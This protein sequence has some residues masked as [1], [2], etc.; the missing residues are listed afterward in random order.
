MANQRTA[1]KGKKTRIVR[2]RRKQRSVTVSAG[3][4][5]TASSHAHS[6]K[7]LAVVLVGPANHV[8]AFAK[9]RPHSLEFFTRSASEVEEL[10]ERLKN[11]RPRRPKPR[12]QD[13][14]EII[15]RVEPWAGS[16]QKA[17]RWFRSQ[18]I[19][20]LGDQTAEAL[21]RTGQA[22]LV[23]RYLDAIAVGGFA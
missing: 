14:E 11:T 1:L 17:E 5:R 19:P 6:P 13:G 12:P 15:A 7:D 3:K 2:R 20:A 22:A 8:M 10:L 9:T 23:R 16:R 21:V 4:P 18:P